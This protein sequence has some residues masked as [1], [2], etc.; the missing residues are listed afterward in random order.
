MKDYFPKCDA[1]CAARASAL[2]EFKRLYEQGKVTS[3][4]FVN[5][6]RKARLYG[7][8]LI[9]PKHREGYGNNPSERNIE[10]VMERKINN[11]TLGRIAN[12]FK[13][14]RERVRQ[15][16]AKYYPNYMQGDDRK[17]AVK[18]R[19]PNPR[20][21]KVGYSRNDVTVIKHEPHGKYKLRCKC[22]REKVC[23][24]YFACKTCG[25]DRRKVI[26]YELVKKEY[27]KNKLNGRQIAEKYGYKEITVLTA[28]RRMGV[29]MRPR[30]GKPWGKSVA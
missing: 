27:T 30:F 4:Q 15:I 28:L 11:Q 1:T 10:I 18:N 17:K 23:G 21:Y 19:I 24:P 26:D 20:I 29:K 16:L 3:T 14:T 5:L 13:I 8:Q 9:K 6:Y 22:G 25:N 2:E 12:K 7:V